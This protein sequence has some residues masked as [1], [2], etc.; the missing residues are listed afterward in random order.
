MYCGIKAQQNSELSFAES[1]Q[2]LRIKS[3][4][5]FY[6]YV[7]ESDIEEA[8]PDVILEEDSENDDLIEIE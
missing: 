7:T 6:N 1:I 4:K 8:T 3:V 2:K 5:F